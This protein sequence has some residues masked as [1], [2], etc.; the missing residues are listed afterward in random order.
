MTP[1]AGKCRINAV[2]LGEVEMNFLR[3]DPV[4]ISRYAFA[5]AASGTRFG[6]GNKNQ[7][8]SPE[9][10]AALEA[11]KASMEADIVGA[12]FEE[13]ATSPSAVAPLADTSDGVPGL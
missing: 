8:W 10:M 9:T 2:E 5:D 7:G 6:M 13:T 11:L 4:L 1:S 3:A 12:L